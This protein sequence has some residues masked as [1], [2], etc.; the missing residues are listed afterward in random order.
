M[1]GANPASTES[2]QLELEAFRAEA[3]AKQVRL[4]QDFQQCRDEAAAE[5][6]GLRDLNAT[7]ASRSNLH[8]VG[9]IL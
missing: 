5:M 7:M 2:L 8:Q 1:Q 4:R 3:E 9:T 6:Q